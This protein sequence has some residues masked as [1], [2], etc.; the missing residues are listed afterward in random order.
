MSGNLQ[1]GV[2]GAI[3]LVDASIHNTVLKC[4]SITEIM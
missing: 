3:S 4:L 1:I 2:K